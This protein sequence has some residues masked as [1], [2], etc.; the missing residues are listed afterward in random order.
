MG[1][2]TKPLSLLCIVG[3]CLGL[4]L[5]GC[6]EG[7]DQET[8]FLYI[9]N[10]YAGTSSLTL[11]GPTG[12]LVSGLPFGSRTE[13]P[14]EV[15]RNVNSD[16]FVLV[17]DGAPV[18]MEFTRPMFSLF[19]QE[20]GTMLI[21]RRSGEE[22]A[23]VMLYRHIR[24]PSPTCTITFDNALSLDNQ[25]MADEFVSYSYQTE[26]NVD[27]TPY[28]NQAHE[29]IAWTRCGPTAIPDEFDRSDL[30]AE[31]QADPWLFPISAEEGGYTLAWGFRRVD[32]RTGYVR[33][34]GLTAE[35]QVVAY[36]YTADFVR[37]LSAA[38]TVV[39]DTLSN[40]CPAPNG[41]Q[42]TTPAGESV[43]LLGPGQVVWDE[44][45]AAACR[46]LSAYEGFPIEPGAPDE[47][48]L[49]T[50]YPQTGVDPNN[51]DQAR[52]GFPIRVRTPI[53]DLIFQNH[54]GS[55]DDYIENTGGWIEVDSFFPAGEQR[56]FVIFG[57]PINAFIDQWNGGQTSVGLD[58]YPY[59]GEISPADG[60]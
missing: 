1:A 2:V 17:L 59:P 5:T 29:Q 44:Q 30:H 37:C 12:K 58:D 50:T 43:T 21:S 53:Q 8:V 54:D 33:S 25:L 23:D 13:E 15:E 60:Q 11:Y 14:I 55:R 48:T 46:T 56:F 36:R 41:A 42:A 4:V 39:E 18:P 35:G 24:T 52:C 28:Y 6:G 31:I 22:F 7:E 3:L 49:F 40:E 26:W 32:P 45:A 27:P 47:I 57:R 34:Q 10:G 16:D 19:P 9:T 20:T 38:V 51:P